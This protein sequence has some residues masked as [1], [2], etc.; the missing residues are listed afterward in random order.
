MPKHAELLLRVGIAFAFV[1]AAISGFIY[2]DAWIGYFPESARILPDAQL[3][4]LWGAIEVIVALWLLSGVYLRMAGI[5]AA[6][7][8]LGVVVFN[9]SQM[10]VVFRDIPIALAALALAFGYSRKSTDIIQ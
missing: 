5:V 2:P 7:L 8:L 4:S 1:Y 6:A 10:I 3:L 9:S